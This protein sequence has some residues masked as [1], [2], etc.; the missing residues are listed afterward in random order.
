MKQILVILSMLT[1]LT[2]GLVA[3]E[4]SASTTEREI[5]LMGGI[6]YPYLPSEYRDYWKK[7]W[8]AG[9]GYG[10][11]FAPGS[12][13]YG[14][15]FATVEYNRYAL[16]DVRYREHFSLPPLAPV[17]AKGAAQTFGVMLNV[18][19]SFSATRRTVA[20]YFLLGVGYLYYHADSLEVGNVGVGGEKSSAICWSF[21]VGIE[22]PIGEKFGMFVQARSL[23][24]VYDQTKQFFPLSGGVKVKL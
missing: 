17:Q 9:I 24:G 23:L 11:S 18:K 10:Y 7:G 2:S 3:Q 6:S 19:G 20:P 14:T 15:V 12:I 16:D 13:G 21:G 1:A 22:V 4:P 5:I 8:N